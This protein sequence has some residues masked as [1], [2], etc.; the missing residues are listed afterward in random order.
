MGEEESEFKH[1]LQ[2]LNLRAGYGV[3]RYPYTMNGSNEVKAAKCEGLC[4]SSE[5]EALHHYMLLYP[6]VLIAYSIQSL[7]WYPLRNL[8]MKSDTQIWHYFTL[9]KG[10]PC[11]NSPKHESKT[12]EGFFFLRVS[13]WYFTLPSW[14]LIF[15]SELLLVQNT[16]TE[17]VKV[18]QS[19]SI[20]F[21]LY[22]SAVHV[23]VSTESTDDLHCKQYWQLKKANSSNLVLL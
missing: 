23:C 20:S 9:C 21:Y 22:P 8:L 15:I 4:N 16:N 10:K 2:V 18:I 11:T 19:L 5:S 6:K 12:E 1:P 17:N 7:K 13:S 3:L 14:C